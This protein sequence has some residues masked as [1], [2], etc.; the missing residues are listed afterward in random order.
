MTF[1]P[2]TAC[3]NILKRAFEEDIQVTPMKL[4][5]LLYFSACEYI[6]LTGEDLFSERFSVWQYGPVLP[7]VYY[8]FQSFHANAITEYAKD[9]NG[10]SYAY[11]EALSPNFKRSFDIV[12]NAFKTMS[13]VELS[14]ITHTDGSAWDKAFRAG[15][16]EIR[17]D[18]MKGDDT[19]R[20]HLQ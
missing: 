14:K 11:N 15:V 7:S 3:N 2:T 4:Q 6:R 8:E 19:Y 9:A 17:S 5:K 16:T 12:W 20:K 13:G 1:L 18:D 10:N